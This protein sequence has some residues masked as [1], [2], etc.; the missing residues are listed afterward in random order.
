MKQG[1]KIFWNWVREHDE[2]VNQFKRNMEL[3]NSAMWDN[4][5]TFEKV[6]DDAHNSRNDS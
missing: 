3:I 6:R 5:E 4:D 2:A 1:H